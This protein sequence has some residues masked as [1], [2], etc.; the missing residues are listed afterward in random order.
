MIFQ[1][2]FRDELEGLADLLTY[3][4]VEDRTDG[5]VIGKAGQ[6]IASFQMMGRD[7]DSSSARDLEAISQRINSAFIRLDRGWMVQFNSFRFESTGYPAEGF[8]PDAATRLIDEERRRQ[9]ESDGRHYEG[10]RVLTLTWLPPS[11]IEQKAKS[12]IR[13]TSEDVAKESIRKQNLAHFKKIIRDVANE[14]RLEMVDVRA[15]VPIVVEDP[16]LPIKHVIDPQI[17]MFHWCATG[18]RQQVAL[19]PETAQPLAIDFLIGSQDFVGGDL[20]RIGKK[21]IKVIGID[22]LPDEGTHAGI[23]EILNRLGVSYRWST[24]FIIED[25]RHASAVMDRHFKKWNQQ[26]RG[27]FDQIIGREGRIN[28]DALKMANDAQSAKN[29]L[30][31]GDVKF[32]YYTGVIV[33]Y[34]ESPDLLQRETDQIVEALRRKHFVAREEDVNAVEAFLG[35]LPGHGYENVRRPMIHTLQLA[36]LLPTTAPWQG[37]DQNPC[38]K[39]QAQYPDQ[40]DVFAPPHWY[41]VSTGNTPVRLSLHVGDV[42]H[43]LI[44]GRTGGGKSTLLGLLMAQWFR[45][46]NAKVFA[47]DKGWSAFALNQACGG[48]HYNI[49]GETSKVG[50][51]PL[52]NV[53]KLGERAWAETW[54]EAML[55]LNA[56]QVTSSRREVLRRTLVALGRSDRDLRTLTHFVGMLQDNEMAQALQYYTTGAGAGGILDG[57]EDSIDLSRFTVFEME[58]LM[59]LDD[60]HVA[61]VLMYLFRMIE[62]Q[63]DGSPVMI[64]L[65]EAWLMLKH[66]LFQEVLAKWLKVLRKANALVVFATQEIADLDNSP[67]RDTIYSACMTRIFLPDRDADTDVS[68]PYYQRLGLTNRQIVLLTKATQKRDYY[69]TS[70]YGSRLFQLGLGPVA[71]ALVGV[72]GIENTEMIRRFQREYREDWVEQWL[73]EKGVNEHM[74]SLFKRYERE[75][76]SFLREQFMVS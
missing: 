42:G 71:L 5:I 66:P 74:T 43:S 50:F 18:I 62:R 76:D 28:Q 14:L 65:D 30:R 73:L 44:V 52:A 20:P 41:G 12:L 45:Y 26:V 56:V 40:R 13:D 29:K 70:P 6:F 3:V 8:F 27:F 1:S 36:D 63:L 31:S 60:K 21:F 49:M 9:Y 53:D 15:L 55:E 16:H 17:G 67:I 4:G 54:I 24:R 72:A 51:C 11:D 2:E 58:A 47:F 10:Q 57:R 34:N 48:L 37:L 25:E 38:D 46:P 69:Y 19:P 32:G 35:S 33:L 39:I 23:L 7:A 64:V 61:P 75:A 22:S 68:M 59:E